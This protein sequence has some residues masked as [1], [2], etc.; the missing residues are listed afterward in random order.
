MASRCHN[1]SIVQDTTDAK[2][3]LSV[4][5]CFNSSCNKGIISLFL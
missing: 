2:Q 1:R 4:E 3:L 5:N